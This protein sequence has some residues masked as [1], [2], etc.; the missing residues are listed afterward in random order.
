M[1][2]N[3][4]NCA[5]ADINSLFGKFYRDNVDRLSRQMPSMVVDGK[6]QPYHAC[7]PQHIRFELRLNGR[8]SA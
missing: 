6:I 2:Q 7:L 5:V 1:T 3:E 4:K 8:N